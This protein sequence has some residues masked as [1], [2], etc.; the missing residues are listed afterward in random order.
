MDGSNPKTLSDLVTPVYRELKDSGWQYFKVDALRHL[1]YEGY[2]SFA[3]YFARK[4]LDREAV[5]RQFASSI[6]TTLGPKVFKLMCWGVRL[7][8]I[9]LFD[10]CSLGNDGFAYGGFSEYNSFN[11][12]VWRNG[13]R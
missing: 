3:D 1:K 5:Y 11:N 13:H 10:G 2:N 8:L 4:Q 6:T 9:G 12:I 7:E